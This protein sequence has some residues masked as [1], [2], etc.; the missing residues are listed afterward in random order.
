MKDNKTNTEL[1]GYWDWIQSDCQ[2]RGVDYGRLHMLN[3]KMMQTG[4]SNI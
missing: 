4:S 2:L 1:T 3:V